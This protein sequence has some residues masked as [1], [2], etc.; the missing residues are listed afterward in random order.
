ME[1]ER[2]K[3]LT[4]MRENIIHRR[5]RRGGGQ[6]EGYCPQKHL[7]LEKLGKFLSN[8]TKIRAICARESGNFC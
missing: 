2:D 5:T 7:N 1:Y 4:K 6:G 3:I 8:S